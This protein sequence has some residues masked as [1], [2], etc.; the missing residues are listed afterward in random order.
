MIKK[1]LL[2]NLCI[3]NSQL[4]CNEITDRKLMHTNTKWQKIIK[5]NIKPE[6]LKW[7]VANKTLNQI[8]PKDFRVSSTGRL[9]I[10]NHYFYNT[11]AYE[12]AVYEQL[13]LLTVM[14]AHANFKLSKQPKNLPLLLRRYMALNAAQELSK[15][16]SRQPDSIDTFSKTVVLLSNPDC[17][18]PRILVIPPVQKPKIKLD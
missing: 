2:I 17:Y 6:L 15:N 9:L 1:F 8:M 4:F 7:R 16:T 12:P 14:I 10:C 3:I 13:Y 11:A 5:E 18:N